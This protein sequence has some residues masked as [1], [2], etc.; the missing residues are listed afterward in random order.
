[1]VNTIIELKEGRAVDPAVG[2]KHP[3][4]PAGVGSR[5]CAREGQIHWQGPMAQL[6]DNLEVQRAYLTF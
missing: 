5:L 6:A 2:T 1:M 4:R 3:F